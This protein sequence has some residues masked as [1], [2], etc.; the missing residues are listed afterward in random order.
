MNITQRI[1]RAQREL[2]Q[3]QS[4][5]TLGRQHGFN[6]KTAGH[7]ITIKEEAGEYAFNQAWMAEVTGLSATAVSRLAKVLTDAGLIE[8]RTQIK[9][10][11]CKVYNIAQ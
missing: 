1:A 7:F 2:E 8:C 9:T 3:L 4:L 11:G 10:N 5:Q 6:V